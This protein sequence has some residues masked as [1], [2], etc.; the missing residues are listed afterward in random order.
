[1][2]AISRGQFLRWGAA[3]AAA[4]TGGGLLAR[5]ARAG[6]PVPT[7]Q[8]DDVGFASFAVVV[9]RTS[10]TWYR[11]ARRAHGFSAAQRAHLGRGARAKAAHVEK[12]NAILGADAVASTDFAT[13]FPKG[14]FDTPAKALA[15]GAG[16]EELLVGVYVDGVA[17]TADDAT[18]LLLGRLLAYDAQQL[19]WLRA[20]AGAAPPGLPDP[21]DLEVAGER[22]D[23]FLSTP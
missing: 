10:L 19:A 20:Q 6:L 18:R 14:S 5:P 12:L 4:A 17:F 16:L 15:L 7:P 23:R 1:M 9:E 8:G 21:L 11:R 3:S 2:T 13:T 22:L